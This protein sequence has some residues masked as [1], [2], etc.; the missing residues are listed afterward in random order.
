MLLCAR[1]SLGAL[2]PDGSAVGFHVLPPLAD[3]RL[4]ELTRGEGT[5]PLV[6]Q[7]AERF[8]QFEGVP[9]HLLG[10]IGQ[11]RSHQDA[12]R[13]HYPRAA[14]ATARLG[15]SAVHVDDVA[16]VH[17]G[18]LGVLAEVLGDV[19]EH[20]LLVGVGARGLVRQGITQ[21]EAEPDPDPELVFDNAYVLPPPNLREGWDG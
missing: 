8:F 11:V 2:D 6:S 3:A 15:D 7:R 10:M 16:V 14:E 4:V 13:P 18:D 9:H 5:S 20:R 21:A 12:V 1:G 19:P 17:V